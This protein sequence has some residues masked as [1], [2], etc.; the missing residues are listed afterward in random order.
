MLSTRVVGTWKGIGIVAGVEVDAGPVVSAIV[1]RRKKRK[2][3]SRLSVVE[4]K[5]QSR[6][7]GILRPGINEIGKLHKRVMP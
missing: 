6:N 5:I 4:V 2:K 3:K 7:P 1:E